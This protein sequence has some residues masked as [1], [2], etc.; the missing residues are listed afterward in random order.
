VS[1]EGREAELAG[2]ARRA[3]EGLPP[4]A[5]GPAAVEGAVAVAVRRWFRREGRQRPA[6]EVAV[7]EV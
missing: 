1:V 6:V 7:L 4:G 5:R 3:A 2:E